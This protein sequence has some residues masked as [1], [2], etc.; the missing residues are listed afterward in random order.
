[1][2]YIYIFY[3]LLKQ[4]NFFFFFNIWVAFFFILD[5]VA[6]VCVCVC[7][8]FLALHTY[9]RICVYMYIMLRYGCMGVCM[10][11]ELA[12]PSLP[13]RRRRLAIYLSDRP[14]T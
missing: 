10:L 11:D 1:M 4:K 13:P 14:R 3:F 9:I 6:D 12:H 7:V 2:K 8:S 5:H